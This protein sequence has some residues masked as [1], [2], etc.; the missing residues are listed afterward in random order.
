MDR[1]LTLVRALADSVEGLTLDEMAEV[2][3]QKR[4]TAERM[5]DVIALHFDLDECE[6]GRR[7]RFRI[8]DSL[9]RHYV[10]P[11]AAE[12]AALHA[13]A[14]AAAAAKSPRAN[15]LE[16]L[17]VK[18]RSSLDD[19]E[20]HRIDPDFSE[21]ARLQRTLVGPGPFA[22]VE[23]DTLS[24]IS[25]AIMAGQ[26]VEF[27]Y[28]GGYMDEPCWRRVVPCGLLHGTVSYMV[29]I[30]PDARFDPTTYRLDRMSVVRVSEIPGAA[31][32]N[33]DLDEWTA[34]SFGI[35]R[36]ASHDI[37]LR[38][39]PGSAERARQWR[40]HPKQEQEELDDGSIRISFSCGGL[41]ELSDHLFTWAGELVIEKPLQLR[42]IMAERLIQAQTLIK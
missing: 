23:P 12:L 31:P 41:R 16:P 39:L 1:M 18:I 15:M 9:R 17:L 25:K 2:V 6:D 27:N 10:R 34:G 3:G 29:A 22:P 24:E 7:K 14:D 38:V 33:F 37:S 30:F 28:L 19:K 13:E 20:K 8:R 4:R 40:F 36:D 5:R 32:E 11:S 42:E 35:W 21:L 26:C